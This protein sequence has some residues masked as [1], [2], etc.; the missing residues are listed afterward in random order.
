MSSL[1]SFGDLPS[2]W[3]PTLKAVPKTSFTVPLRF[4]ANDLK[5]IVL[6]IEII[7]SSGIDLVCFMFFSFFL[8]LGGS[9]KAL[10]T[11]DEAEGTTET[12]ACRF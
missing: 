12:A 4:F 10:M 9:F 11:K 2:T 5:R 6:A 8:S 7:S 1:T 3:Q